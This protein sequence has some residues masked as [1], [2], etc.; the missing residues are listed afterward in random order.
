MTKTSHELGSRR[1]AYQWRR[2]EDRMARVGWA[3]VALT[4][5]AVILGRQGQS[6]AL[7]L[8]I[9]L[10]VL[11]SLGLGAVTLSNLSA[12]SARASVRERA[13]G[14]TTLPEPHS[15]E[16]DLVDPV[17]GHI[18]RPAG[19]NSLSREEFKEALRVIRVDETPD[20]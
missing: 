11:A 6:W 13:A 17:T 2:I 5:P 12:F 18:I 15:R 8:I 19:E 3:L 7:P 4:V 1:T 20:N 16:L 14:Y 9:V 10:G